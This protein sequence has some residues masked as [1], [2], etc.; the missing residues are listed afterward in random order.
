VVNVWPRRPPP[1][2]YD[3]WIEDL[4]RFIALDA[5][6]ATAAQALD[7]AAL[8]LPEAALAELL[9]ELEALAGSTWCATS[10]GPGSIRCGWRGSL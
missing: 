6:C 9:G 10:W 7:G 8:D 2:G 1:G 5:A 3:P 4:A